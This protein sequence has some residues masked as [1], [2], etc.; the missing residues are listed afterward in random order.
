MAL[1][2]IKATVMKLYNISGLITSEIITT[3]FGLDQA[4]GTGTLVS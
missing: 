1:L 2:I 4:V 3:S